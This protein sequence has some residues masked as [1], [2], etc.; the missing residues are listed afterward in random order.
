MSDIT[1]RLLNGTTPIPSTIFSVHNI[2][3]VNWYDT[4]TNQTGE[5]SLN[6]PDGDYQVD[7]IWL[8]EV[9][10]WYERNQR[11]TVF[12]G[13]LVGLSE[14]MV[15]L[16]EAKGNYAVTGTLKKGTE[17][18]SN[19]PLSVRTVS[20]ETKV[21]ETQTDNSGNFTLHLPLGNYHIDGVWVQSDNLWYEIQKEFVVQATT[22]WNI[23]VV[24]SSSF[25]F[26]GSLVKGDNQLA[27]VT[28]SIRTINGEEKWYI[29]QT[30]EE[31][32][33]NSFLQAG[34]Y[35]LEGIWLDSESSWYGLQ[36]EIVIEGSTQMTI[37]V[38][39]SINGNVNGTL[40]KVT[41]PLSLK[42]FSLYCISNEKW[43]DTTTDENGN[44]VFNLPNG[45]YSLQGV[46]VEEEG[47]WYELNYNFIVNERQH[48]NIDILEIKKATDSF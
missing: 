17:I 40:T 45:T 9:G 3:N 34:T 28:F 23:N 41:D 30:D 33:F 19:V 15:N 18:L 26:S 21:Y 8:S 27:N 1:G 16:A 10:I 20:G 13:Q 42:V 12:N 7:G 36:K 24:D 2:Y 11:F 31:G 29:L 46:W 32:N 37:N 47:K 22:E 14:L 38:L 5:F 35:L 43:Y 48:L 39:D 4:I 6:L 25:P 44:F